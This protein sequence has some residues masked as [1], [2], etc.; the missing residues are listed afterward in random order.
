MAHSAW[1]IRC[2]PWLIWCDPSSGAIPHQVRSLALGD[3]PW[4]TSSGAIPV[5]RCDPWL[6]RCDPWPWAADPRPAYSHCS[7][8][9]RSQPRP[10]RDPHNA[11]PR[12]H[13]FLASAYSIL[14]EGSFLKLL[15]RQ[16]TSMKV[17]VRPF[18]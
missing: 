1:L 7:C 12:M 4:L 15:L 10:C 14:S 11:D 16:W 8:S 17:S 13:R 6:I 18:T 2:D 9:T 5:I 3:R